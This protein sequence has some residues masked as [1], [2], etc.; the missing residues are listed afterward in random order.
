MSARIELIDDS[1]K[2]HQGISGQDIKGIRRM[3]WH[4][5]PKKDGTSTD[6]P[7]G[8]ANKRYYP[9]ISEWGNPHTA[10]RMYHIVN[11]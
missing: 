2:D 6:M 8:A 10:N 9:W 3:T 1:Y 7:W 5:E 11:T 4:W